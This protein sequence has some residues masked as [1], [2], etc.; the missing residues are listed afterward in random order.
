MTDA[1]LAVLSLLVEQ[2]RHG[3][4]IETVI[5]EREMREWTDIG[6]SSIYYVLGRLE[7]QG[8]VAARAEGTGRGPARKVYSPTNAG[9]EAFGG[10]TYEVL[11]TLRAPNPF[12][13]GL[14]NIICLPDADAASALRSYRDALEEKRVRVE[15]R[16]GESA[17]APPHVADLFDYGIAMLQAET[18]WVSGLIAR[19]ESEP[20][21]ARKVPKTK[22]RTD[23]E[24]V[25]L[26]A[27][28]MAVVHTCGDP[29]ELGEGV[30]KALYGAVYTLK[31]DLKKRR[32]RVQ[33]RG[34]PGSLVRRREL[35]RRAAGPVG[36]S[37]G[38]PDPRGR[39]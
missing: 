13:L 2:P 8:L 15:S 10:A 34:A 9:I 22:V 5:E 30:F 1:E 6:F 4:E 3:Y 31:F 17:D 28:K 37:V 19:K 14:S 33:D 16:R 25:E 35:G 32:D 29:A 39:R 7:R 20:K 24:I 18:A 11:S 21:G 27:R 36:S 38:D 23:P 26:P 12:M